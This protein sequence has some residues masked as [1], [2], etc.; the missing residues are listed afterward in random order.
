MGD[1]LSANN[2][3]FKNLNNSI[4]K[5]SGLKSIGEA[6]IANQKK[7]LNKL[8]TEVS[9]N[10]ATANDKKALQ[11]RITVLQGKV[12]ELE[13]KMAALEEELAA[14]EPK[15][16]QQAKLITA[17]VESAENLSE[18]LK[19]DQKKFME[20]AYADVMYEYKAGLLGKNEIF[21]ELTKRLA[22]SGLSGTAS[23]IE[24]I[25]QAL[26]NKRNELQPLIDE[27]TKI[28]DQVAALERQYG[29]TKASFNLLGATLNQI[30]ATETTFT[31]ADVGS[32]GP[33]YS[34]GKLEVLASL[35][36]DPALNVPAT[37]T[38]F[39]NGEA[40]VVNN[41]SIEE[42]GEKYKDFMNIP[43]SGGDSNS[44]DNVAVQKL[45]EA[46]DA[47][48]LNDLA[49]SGLPKADMV[50]F[51]ANNFG[52][53]NI[54][55][56]GN[57]SLT[58][59]Y[60]HYS[61][62]ERQAGNP[63][64]DDNNKACQ[65]YN[66]VTDFVKNSIDVPFMGDVNT[67]DEN[68]G[69]TISSNAQLEALSNSYAYVLETLS[70]NGFTFKEAMYAMFDSEIGLFK[71]C[72]IKYDLDEQ[73][74]NACYTIES[75]GDKATADFYAAFNQKVIDTY[76]VAAN[77]SGGAKV[78]RTDEPTTV[79]R[80]DPV[81]FKQ[82]DKEFAFV[83]DRDG[84]GKFSGPNDFVG[85]TGDIKGD[86]KSLDKNK[87]GKLS[88]DELKN[89]KIISTDYQDNK[90]EVKGREYNGK[91]FVSS[92]TTQ[93]DYSLTNA[94]AMGISSI[95]LDDVVQNG[96]TGKYDANNSEIFNDTISFKMNGK[97]VT[98]QRKDDTDEF[99][100]TIYGAAEGKNFNLGLSDAQADAII[101]ESYGE[102]DQMFNSYEDVIGNIN[103]IRGTD[104]L[105]DNTRDL[106]NE[107]TDSLD[108]E[109]DA[110]LRRGNNA[111][112]AEDSNTKWNNIEGQVRSIA[113]RRGID[114]D[115]T[116]AK[117]L[118]LLTSANTAS[119]VVDEYES[120]IENEK[121]IAKNQESISI[122]WKAIILCVRAGI[123]TSADEILDILNN[124]KAKDAEGVVDY[125]LE[126]KGRTMT[127][128]DVELDLD[129]PRTQ[130]IL[131]AFRAK[132]GNN[133]L[134]KLYELCVAQQDD[135][136]FMQ[137]KSAKELA[138]AMA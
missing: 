128:V 126:T 107:T 74:N 109:K 113:N 16:K 60:G 78:E 86:M 99:L 33:I 12:E 82:G 59:P 65:I 3:L 43:A 17:L 29:L 79:N 14:K 75:G 66:K 37:N 92:E 46:I 76:G 81:T 53:A 85:A 10:D 56:N 120:M 91:K 25:A 19:D 52:G 1:K 62:A 116:Q 35:T 4:M 44:Y 47:G 36:D 15:V 83:I 131:G 27:T 95:D 50:D 13:A 98:A 61:N 101:N 124:D 20:E 122:A 114:I 58:I 63:I 94:K 34:V 68:A 130:E 22:N 70:S 7:Q 137:G 115:M 71:D 103:I 9:E 30:G 39:A 55:K 106:F 49:A 8:F 18:T 28:V 121:A 72:G 110:Y 112:T 23:K 80:T 108:D 138:E 97:E 32:A 96:S 21:P 54:K 2:E 40:P 38:N 84:D 123:E 117:G 5:D 134:E 127:P 67:W 119:E 69:N 129:D 64:V 57:N 100:E 41:M 24:E 136:S 118:F 45:G 73:K 125:L 104:Q 93:V 90:S 51:L 26:N 11:A 111:A 77:S 135:R 87:D 105:A 102:F 6:T 42:I 133:A 132:F 31:N 88:N 48:L 89:L